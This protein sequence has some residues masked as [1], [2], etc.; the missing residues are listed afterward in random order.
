[1][2]DKIESIGEFSFENCEIE[3][4]H[5]SNSLTEIPDCAF[6]FNEIEHID[7]PQNIRR[8][9]SCAFSGNILDEELTIPEGVEV[10]ESESFSCASI[11]KVSL[12]STLTE[13]AY[14]FYYEEMIDDSEENK[15]YVKVHPDNKVYYSKGGILYSRATGKEVLGKAGRK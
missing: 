15:P 4:L 9:G 2:H 14:D 12:P 11:K 3:N 13:I 8:I 6:L 7:I 10:I 1:M 5:L